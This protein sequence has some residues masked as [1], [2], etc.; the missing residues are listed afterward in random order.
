[1]G[2]LR[3]S[4]LLYRSRG[5]FLTQK[6]FSGFSGL[7]HDEPYTVLPEAPNLSQGQ[8]ILQHILGES[9]DHELFSRC[10]K[11]ILE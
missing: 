7:E 4:V 10:H 1:M 2:H 3:N 11:Q 8:L 5:K 9:I 6:Y